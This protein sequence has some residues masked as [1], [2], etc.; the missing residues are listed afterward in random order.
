[1]AAT[2]TTI[3][4]PPEKAQPTESTQSTTT[5]SASTAQDATATDTNP[6]APATLTIR[7]LPPGTRVV[8]DNAPIGA[9]GADGTFTYSTIASGTHTMQLSAR[10]YDAVTITRDFASGQSVALSIADIKLTRA[11]AT[12]ELQA[13]AGTD[14]T[15]A[16]AG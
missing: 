5:A 3:S 6:Q 7:G 10:G 9:A 1:P 13:D 4:T 15:L 2:T 12:L 16:Q 14:I 8:L 11:S